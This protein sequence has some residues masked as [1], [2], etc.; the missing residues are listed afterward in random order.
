[1]CLEGENK[2]KM[3]SLEYSIGILGV[4]ISLKEYYKT[5]FL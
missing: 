5:H 4:G 2:L 1:M 3:E